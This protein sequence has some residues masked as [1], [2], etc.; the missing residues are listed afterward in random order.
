M[1]LKSIAG[2][3]SVSFLCGIFALAF[4][5]YFSFLKPA[6]IPSGGA[7]L[8]PSKEHWFGTD[9]LGIDLF[10]AL[11]HG[12]RSTLLLASASAFIAAVGGS[13]VGMFAGYS[14]GT[15]DR[16]FLGLADLFVSV[17]DL[18]LMVVLSAFAGP[19]LKNCILA[20]SLVSW[21]APAKI[22]RSEITKIKTE[23]YVQLSQAYGAG[24]IHI[25][26]W[27]FWKPLFSI[28]A[29]GAVRVMNKAILSEASLAYLGLGDPLSKS[30]GMIITRALDFPNIYLTEFWKWWLVIPVA[31]LSG[32]VLSV[33]VIGQAVEKAVGMQ[34]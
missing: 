19:S 9:D 27:H 10:A 33:A 26:V 24:F 3:I 29:A 6:H 25:F 14:G 13:I 20:I 11:C 31:L 23:T 16:F 32:T 30:W 5:S 8:P 22:A 4:L 21:V 17:P 7:L 18:L 34:K 15:I 12:A 28:T 2:I 1:H